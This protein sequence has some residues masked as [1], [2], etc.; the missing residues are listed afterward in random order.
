M[1]NNQTKQTFYNPEA[2]REAFEK[3][4]CQELRTLAGQVNRRAIIYNLPASS[5]LAALN[6]N[7]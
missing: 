2:T 6:P 1:M 7:D 5:D 3:K 4:R